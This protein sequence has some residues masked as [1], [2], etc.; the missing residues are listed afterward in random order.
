MLQKGAHS[1]FLR[2]HAPAAPLRLHSTWKFSLLR[3]GLL[4][5]YLDPVFVIIV[6]TLYE[7]RVFDVIIALNYVFSC[8][9]LA[10]RT[11]VDVFLFSIR[12]TTSPVLYAC[13][14]KA[15]WHKQSIFKCYTNTCEWE[16]AM[17]SCPYHMF[18]KNASFFFGI[19][20]RFCWFQTSTTLFS[21]TLKYLMNT[22][23]GQ[24]ILPHFTV[25]K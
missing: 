15:E 1:V 8:L 21:L 10:R 17:I 7:N 6:T 3:H 14:F 25:G 18:C 12:Y 5:Y 2:V 19:I 4:C 13:I 9:A 11:T 24:E 23:Y 16:T 22:N 20:V